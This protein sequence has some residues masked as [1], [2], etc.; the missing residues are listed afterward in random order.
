[1]EGLVFLENYYCLCIASSRAFPSRKR[2]WPQ[3]IL[4]IPVNPI[5][6][7]QAEEAIQKIPE[8]KKQEI[9]KEM[10]ETLTHNQFTQAEFLMV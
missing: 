1:M 9:V 7:K 8:N 5:A 3:T 6:I 2:V 10:R 4:I